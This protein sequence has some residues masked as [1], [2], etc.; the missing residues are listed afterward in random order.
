[1]HFSSQFSKLFFISLLSLGIMQ[2]CFNVPSESTAPDTSSPSLVAGDS[3]APNPAPSPPNPASPDANDLAKAWQRFLTALEKNI[4][5]ESEENFTEVKN[6]ATSLLE[7]SSAL[8]PNLQEFLET[9]RNYPESNG[10]STF[11]NE[12]VKNALHAGISKNKIPENALSEEKKAETATGIIQSLKGRYPLGL[13]DTTTPEKQPGNSNNQ[14]NNTTGQEK[15]PSETPKADVPDNRASEQEETSSTWTKFI[16]PLVVIALLLF[17]FKRKLPSPSKV[18]RL[19]KLKQEYG[20]D[21]IPERLRQQLSSLGRRIST[22]ETNN[23]NSI[24][25][26]ELLEQK[27]IELENKVAELSQRLKRSPHVSPEKNTEVS[28]SNANQGTTNPKRGEINRSESDNVDRQ[29]RQKVMPVE[30]INVTS[31][32]Q[33]SGE[34]PYF[35][36]TNQR[37]ELGIFKDQEGYCY[38]VPLK[39]MTSYEKLDSYFQ[40][41]PGS[42]VEGTVKVVQYPIVT[43]SGEGWILYNYGIIRFE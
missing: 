18:A 34:Y 41:E 8:Q 37:S 6:A 5:N 24:Y 32:R 14:S 17:I 27:V 3:P 43:P 12:L 20:P 39:Q 9:V 31:R 33:G 30:D 4:I 2:G 36:P 19:F 23:E 11:N 16:L 21:E 38:L 15:G 29:T 10:Y 13:Q 1:M 7:F 35:L 42:G 26:I 40:L 28:I 25:K 22:F